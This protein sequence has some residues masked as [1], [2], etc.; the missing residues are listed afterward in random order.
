MCRFQKLSGVEGP[1]KYLLY[2]HRNK[3]KTKSRYSRKKTSCGDQRNNKAKAQLVEL[4]PLTPNKKDTFGGMVFKKF[5]SL[6]LQ[7]KDDASIKL[8]RIQ[9]DFA[10]YENHI[11]ECK[12]DF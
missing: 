12:C 10:S 9:G 11:F 6:L 1:Y 2:N 8:A 5:R 7:E 3:R 4:M